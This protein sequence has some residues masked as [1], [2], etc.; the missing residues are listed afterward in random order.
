MT[1]RLELALG[2]VNSRSDFAVAGEWFVIF[3]VDLNC[4]TF[5]RGWLLVVRSD[6]GYSSSLR[7]SLKI[8]VSVFFSERCKSNSLKIETNNFI[9]VIK[10]DSVRWKRAMASANPT[11]AR[12]SSVPGRLR[13]V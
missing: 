4:L 11:H 2:K 6:F 12:L 13:F 5:L 10:S 1:H 8:I 9:P 7:L 3:E